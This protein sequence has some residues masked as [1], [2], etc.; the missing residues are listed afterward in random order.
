MKA[1]GAF[2]GRPRE[3]RTPHNMPPDI[4]H[5][6]PIFERCRGLQILGLEAQG[7]LDAPSR[8]PELRQTQNLQLLAPTQHDGVL[9]SCKPATQ[10][11]VCK[12]NYANEGMFPSPSACKP[13]I[14]KWG[15]SQR[16]FDGP[17]LIR[18]VYGASS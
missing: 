3:L 8:L 11:F 7:R 16:A 18:R 9:A 13:R 5:P 17:G 14:K 2:E 6:L 4:A 10:R 15:P 12:K 1:A